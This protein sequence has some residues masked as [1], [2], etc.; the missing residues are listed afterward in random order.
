MDGEAG[1]LTPRAEGHMLAETHASTTVV[2]EVA[3]RV[4]CHGG[5]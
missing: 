4:A 5:I 2:G 3:I 1:V